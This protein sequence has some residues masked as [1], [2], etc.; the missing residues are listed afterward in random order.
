MSVN[1]DN[2]H[3]LYHYYEASIGPF[4][5]LSELPICEAE[6][7]LGDIKS[8]AKTFAAKRT[9]DYMKIRRELEQKAR[10]IFIHKGGEPI[11]NVPHYMTLGP[12]SWLLD[13]YEDGKELCIHID[14]FSEGQVSFTYGDLFPTMRYNDGKPYRNTIYT[15]QEIYE[16]IKT[17]GLPQD[18]NKTGSKGPERYIEV[19]IWDDEPIKAYLA[20]GNFKGLPPVVNSE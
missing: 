8:R 6:K 17:Y 5:N 10:S 7:I 13:W 18:W 16:I 12:C 1:I 2:I 4:I 14:M 3:Y 9:S 19:Q 20:K 11:R 15:K